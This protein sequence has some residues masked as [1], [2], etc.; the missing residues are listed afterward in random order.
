M[1]WLRA[2]ERLF[3]FVMWIVSFAFAAFLIGLG[4][5]VIA[6]LPR[7]ETS[8]SVD[9]FVA[10]PPALAD[11]QAAARRITADTRD[12]QREREQAQLVATNA[13]GAYAAAQASFRNWIAAR[14]ATT[15]PD[16]DPEVLSRTSDLDELKASQRTAD[17]AV[18]Q[19]DRRLLNLNQAAA[20]NQR[21]Q[22][23]MRRAAETAYT[24]ALNWQQL[25]VFL[26]RLA[27][28]LPLIVVAA[29]L[30]A[31]KRKSDYWPLMRGFVLFALFTFFVELVPYLPSY[32]GYV[33]SIVGIVLTAVAGHY[34]IR[35]MRAYLARRQQAEQ[36]TEAERRQAMSRDDALKKMAGNVCPGCERPI[37]ANGPAAAN[38]CV[39]CGMT[40]FDTCGAC[41]TRKNAF[42]RYCPA[43]GTGASAEPAPPAAPPANPA[44]APA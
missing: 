15:R 44:P 19:I 40:L 17:V 32:G 39:H 29:W 10:D 1:K 14:T 22:S 41:G 12:A 23:E 42:F 20:A 18:E 34:V 35:S 37:Q 4:G 9:D 28:T 21:A 5:R 13:A 2:P 11:L 36:R 7:L 25:R 43:C 31:K 6:D 8:L 27:V 30:V 3:A 16:Q 26:V 38:F 33:R 24:R